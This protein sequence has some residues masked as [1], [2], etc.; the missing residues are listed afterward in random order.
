MLLKQIE[1]NIKK[2]LPKCKVEVVDTSSDHIGHDAGGAHILVNITD[3][4]FKGV[5]LALQHKKIYEILDEELKDG[6]IHALRIKTRVPK[7]G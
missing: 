2:S 4:S 5:S 1:S 3:E 7:D 6:T